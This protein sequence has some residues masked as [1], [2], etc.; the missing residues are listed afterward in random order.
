MSIE[1]KERN[2]QDEEAH[3]TEIPGKYAQLAMALISRYI[4][5]VISMRSDLDTALTSLRILEHYTLA[6]LYRVNSM[7]DPYDFEKY[8]KRYVARLAKSEDIE[9]P[10]PDGKDAL[11]WYSEIAAMHDENPRRELM[12]EGI[13]TLATLAFIAVHSKLEERRPE[14]P[15]AQSILESLGL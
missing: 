11:T 15:S 12:R 9:I 14:E 8:I 2:I 5:D 13:A 6:I 3:E 7:I 4:P 10:P 1:E